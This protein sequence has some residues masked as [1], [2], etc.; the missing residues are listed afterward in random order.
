MDSEGLFVNFDEVPAAEKG[1]LMTLVPPVFCL[2]RDR[3][4]LD[5]GGVAPEKEGEAFCESSNLEDEEVDP[6][7]KKFDVLV[8]GYQC[9]S[10]SLRVKARV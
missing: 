8:R 1:V 4:T 5:I 3:S 7:G 10:G 9:L 2:L 6:R